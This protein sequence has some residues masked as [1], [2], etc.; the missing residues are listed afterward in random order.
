MSVGIQPR[1]TVAGKS[2][3]SHGVYAPFCRLLL[4]SS[5]ASERRV[6]SAGTSPTARRLP[7]DELLGSSRRMSRGERW[8]VWA[9]SRDSPPRPEPQVVWE[10]H[11][12]S[13]LSF[14]VYIDVYLPHPPAIREVGLSCI[15]VLNEL[16]IQLGNSEMLVSIYA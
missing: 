9:L 3:P 6:F 14:G 2:E 12:A 10:F 16:Y 8:R 4:G 5:Y 1:R 7:S 13:S 15:S 11:P